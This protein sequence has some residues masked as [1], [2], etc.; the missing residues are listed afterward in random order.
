MLKRLVKKIIKRIRK[1]SWI[2]ELEK[3]GLVIGKTS[4]Q[5]I[6]TDNCI[7]SLYPWLIEIG[8][9][10]IISTGVSILAHDA[11]T[12]QISGFSRL[13]RVTIG[14][15]VYIGHNATILCNVKIGNNVVIGAKS[16]VNKNLQANG[17]YAGVPAKYICSIEEFKKKHEK[18]KAVK[19]YF[20]NNFLYYQNCATKEE[21][22]K[23]KKA[24]ENTDGYIKSRVIE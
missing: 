16:L 10:V 1:E 6:Y 18:F 4:K 24:L 23:M 8:E 20:E 7:D 17:V 22:L 12:A 5:T 3:R 9:H 2:D 21:R 15:N 19:P 11:S 13:G 14:D